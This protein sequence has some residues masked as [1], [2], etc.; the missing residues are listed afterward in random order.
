[1]I[2]I[3]MQPGHY[4]LVVAQ[5]VFECF[6]VA[7]DIVIIERGF[8]V[9]VSANATCASIQLGATPATGGINFGAL[10]FGGA[11]QLIVSGNVAVGG[12]G[13]NFRRG[14]IN[15]ANGSLL[16]AGIVTLGSSG[17]T[18]GTPNLIDMT[19]GGTSHEW[20]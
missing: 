20:T 10:T 19:S 15:F 9:T 8:T 4:L 17:A 12:N 3:P 11:F 7:G 2:G 1:M 16:D 18:P 6:P 14:T 5:L 13:N